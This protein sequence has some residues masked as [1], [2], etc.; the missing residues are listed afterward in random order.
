M[1]SGPALGKPEPRR[2][3]LFPSRSTW[4]QLMTL[5]VT[6]VVCVTPPPVAVM[7]MERL[8]SRA[9]EPVLM[10]MVEVPDP[11]AIIELGLKVTVTLLP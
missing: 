1:Q 7:V 6:V 2:S 9:R 8:P 3:G 11:G 5:K 10:V 4:R